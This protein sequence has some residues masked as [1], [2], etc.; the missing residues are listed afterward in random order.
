MRWIRGLK[1]WQLL[2]I[3]TAAFL[4][5]VALCCAWFGNPLRG[6]GSSSEAS[7][8]D[9][10]LA[11][12][13]GIVVSSSYPPRWTCGRWSA[14]DGWMYSA[15]GIAVGLSYIALPGILIHLRSKRPDILPSRLSFLFSAFILACGASHFLDATLF[16]WPAY[17]LNA[18]MLFLTACISWA[19]A[20]TLIKNRSNILAL[21]SASQLEQQVQERTQELSD[22]NLELQALKREAEQASEAKSRFL[23]T[24]S[25]EFRT[26][27]T[28]IRGYAEELQADATCGSLSPEAKTAIGV[29]A[30]SAEHIISL[31]ND[32]LDLQKIESGCFIIERSI[33]ATEALRGTVLGTI[34]RLAAERGIALRW[35]VASDFP[36]HFRSDPQRVTQILLNLLSNAVKFTAE[37]EVT[38]RTFVVDHSIV[39]EV[40]DT[41]I[42]IAE[43]RHEAIFDE[44]VQADESTTRRFG[45]TGLGLAICRR[46]A[47]LLGGEVRLVK[48]EPGLGTTMRLELPYSAVDVA[49]ERKDPA[50]A[51]DFDLRGLRILVAEDNPV[52]QKLIAIVLGRMNA[53]VS[54][55]DD[56]QKAIERIREQAD[57]FDAIILDQHMPIMDGLAAAR[58]L[59]AEGWTRP[60]L[61]LTAAALEED[62]KAM[63]DAGCDDHLTKPIDRRALFEALSAVATRAR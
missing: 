12:T 37:G 22:R 34:G 36:P 6:M 40:Q 63:L 20:I 50:K 48:S 1:V 7:V 4:A 16:W 14:F 13:T 29:I 33:L 60:I 23:S 30:N 44:F 51:L 54:L 56:G 8:F 31:I 59:R 58:T 55:V 62:R 5:V 24:M 45:G 41:G 11:W 35:E 21:R 18:L 53:K 46:L 57:E 15:S 28:A 26:P 38:I 10:F 47:R 17:R 49:H 25:H 42:G 9:Q 2:S 3:G 19:T 61:A 43:A 32:C 27:L 39:F 52:N